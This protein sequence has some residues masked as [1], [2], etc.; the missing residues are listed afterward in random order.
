[1]STIARVTDSTSEVHALGLLGSWAVVPLE[2]E[3]DG[4]RLREGPELSSADFYALFQQ[5]NA[6]PVTIP[7]SP[8]RFA[9]QYRR[10][11]ESHERLL[12]IHLSGEL[13]RTVDH[14]REGADR[15][16]AS[17][18][19]LVVDSRLA[20][21]P[22][23][24]LCLETEA[25]L[26]GGRDPEEVAGEVE[27]I[28]RATRVYFSVYTLDFLYLS[29]RLD[30]SVT[31]GE[32]GQDDRPILALEDGRLSLIERVIGETTRVERMVDL[33]SRDFDAGEPLVAACVH[34]G[35]RGREAAG[36]LEQVLGEVRRPARWYRAPL[37]PVLCAHTGFDVCGIAAYPASLSAVSG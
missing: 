1:M 33:L 3:I 35:S 36:Q 6:I 32:S 12:S 2:I 25:R 10:L 22:L 16:G 20:G 9:A 13:S 8:E 7:P 17:D 37:G 23:G 5:T 11:L 26:V 18:R 14:A 24:L 29:G 27:A 34:A 21:L 19:V 4:R 30:R 28:A 31:R 15:I